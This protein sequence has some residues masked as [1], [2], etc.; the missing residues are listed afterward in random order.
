MSAFPEAALHR[1]ARGA[2]I[3]PGRRSWR[4][5]LRNR[6]A[7]WALLFLAGVAAAALAAPWIAPH[8]PLALAGPA[9][10]PPGPRFWLGTDNLGRDVLSDVVYGARVSLVVGVLAA[11]SSTM[12]GVALGAVSGFLGGGADALV[13][14]TTEFFQ[15]LPR[16]FLA[17]VI[18]A[19]S[20]PGLAKVIFVIAILG[21]PPV[22][23]LVRGEFLRLRTHEFVEAA[24]AAGAGPLM[25]VVREILPNALAPAV[26]AGSLDVAQAILLEAGLSFFGL[27]DPSRISWGTMINTAQ[28][29]LGEAWWLS[30][31]PG[32]AILLTVLSVNLLGDGLNDVL[33]PRT[34]GG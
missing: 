18:I 16:F 15:V 14:R 6:A 31:F 12:L 26:V 10:A 23:R 3:R 13:M 9:L 19:V 28:Q 11:A 21:W 8:D 2:E 7:V 29:F 32:L 33:N 25:I 1:P 30:A 34:A 24:R 5:F 27:G 22:A 20:G 17:L 4:R